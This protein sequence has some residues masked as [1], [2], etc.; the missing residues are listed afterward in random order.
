EDGVLVQTMS[1][2]NLGTE[3]VA[4]SPDGQRLVS[5]G[6]TEGTGTAPRETR[7]QLW[8]VADGSLLQTI[9][10]RLGSVQ[11]MVISPDG[12]TVASVSQNDAVRL[13]RLSDGT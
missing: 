5:V 1:G 8:R 3:A 2:D 7:V 12:E 6:P 9:S 13:W 4:F 10:P 11:S